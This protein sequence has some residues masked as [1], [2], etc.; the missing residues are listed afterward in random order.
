MANFKMAVIIVNYNGAAYLHNCLSSVEHFLHN[1]PHDIVVVDNA[2]KDRSLNLI[3]EEFPQARII[4]N[5]ENL[6]FAAAMNQGIKATNASYLLWLNPD[7][8][9]LDNGF[10]ELYSYM[11]RHPKTGI[12]GPQIVN[13][14]HSIQ[15][16]CRSFPS[17]ETALFNRYSLLTRLFPN[18]PFSRKYLKTN[19]NHQNVTDTDWVSGCCLLVRRE[20]IQQI[21][22][23]DES[24]FMY[25]E[26]VDFCRRAWNSGWKV[27]YHPSAHVM[28]QIAGSSRK[29]KTK[30]VWEHHRSMW[31][32]YK[33][34]YRRNFFKDAAVGLII[35]IRAGLK[36]LQSM[37]TKT[38]A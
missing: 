19:W 22:L 13:P 16:S 28:H 4:C 37:L 24:F 12:L 21:G 20:M 8:E 1:I 26:D 36:I 6:G 11:E 17:Y 30:M 7:A 9:L 29:V 35:K 14:D 33:K 10:D 2:S 32:Y 38:H 31:H 15:L 34:H 25:C 23:L 5:H 18:N 27:Q 3:R